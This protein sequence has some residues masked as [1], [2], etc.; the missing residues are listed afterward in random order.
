MLAL[1][2][3][4]LTDT[5][6]ASNEQGTQAQSRLFGADNSPNSQLLIINP[7][8]GAATVVGP[9]GLVV[10]L[11]GLDFAP[12]GS[13]WGAFRTPSGDF[14]VTINT[15][16]GTATPVVQMQQ[17]FVGRGIEFARDPDGK[18]I[19]L[20]VDSGTNSLYT[21]NITTGATSFVGPIGFSTL[22]LA[23]SPSGSYFTLNRSV[24][25]LA[26]INLSTG[27]G[28]NVGPL[29]LPY[30]SSIAAL[31]F[32]P[33]GQLFGADDA[34]KNLIQIEPNTGQA[35]VVG[36]FGFTT[37][38]GGL[39]FEPTGAPL[40]L[41]IKPGSCPNSFNRKSRGVLPVALVGDTAFDVGQ[42][43]LATV[44]LERSDG[45]GGSVQPNEGPPGPHSVFEDVATPFPG[46]PC[47]CHDLAGDGIDDLS[48]KFKSQEVVA[49]L[50]L[51]DLPPGA[52]VELCVGGELLDGTE[53][54][55]CDCIRIV[56]APDIDGDGAVSAAD[57]LMLLGAWGPCTAAQECLADLDEDGNVSISDLIVLLANWG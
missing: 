57:L 13:L 43:D 54:E 55:A 39:A 29:R 17:T 22:S 47:D 48:M 11:S 21:V 9:F 5:L 50:E 28:T 37:S 20:L 3:H 23:E 44:R 56:P 14:L 34:R 4:V 49:A 7:A 38:V 36:P 1:G 53:F 40:A 19:L 52:P 30:N 33:T 41:D 2:L 45:I 42:A 15:T 27:A 46:E 51:N 18:L 24:D 31:A 8:T 16:T 6:T 25:N 12:D 26:T 35:I 32:S 10:F